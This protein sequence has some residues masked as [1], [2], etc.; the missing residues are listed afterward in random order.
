MEVTNVAVADGAIGGRIA[1]NTIV[2]LIG[3][4]G[5]GGISLLVL[6]VLARY[7]GTDRIG[8]YLLVLSF[9]AF[10]FFSSLGGALGAWILRR[11]ER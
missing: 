8:E 7:L 2:Q 11:R 3:R 4:F 1:R 5:T 6:M 10:L 9:L